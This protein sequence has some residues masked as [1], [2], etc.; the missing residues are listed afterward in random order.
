[1]ANRIA[2][3]DGNR[4]RAKSR[5]W[6]QLPQPTMNSA[7][8]G[9]R[10][11][12]GV[13]PVDSHHSV[14]CATDS[15]RRIEKQADSASRLGLQESID[16]EICPEPRRLLCLG[17]FKRDSRRIGDAA[18]AV[19]SCDHRGCIDHSGL[20]DR[21]YKPFARHVERRALRG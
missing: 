7:R 5:V 8:I 6:R 14:R 2:H 12:E 1:M 10:K 11:S 15:G 20:A 16:P 9:A 19:E 17:C 13:D 21:R 18:Y 4:N 3:G